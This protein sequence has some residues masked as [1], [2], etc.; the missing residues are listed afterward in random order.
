MDAAAPHI[1]FAS[2]LDR[3][4]EWREALSM[5]FE[6]FR[7]STGEIEDPQTVDVALVW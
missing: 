6:R 5:Q 4:S 1:Y 2:D 7:F 3:A